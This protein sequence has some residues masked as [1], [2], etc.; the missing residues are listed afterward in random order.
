MIEIKEWHPGKA[1]GFRCK[2]PPC[3]L[4]VLCSYSG[5]LVFINDRVVLLGVYFCSALTS[6]AGP[7]CPCKAAA[8]ELTEN[9]PTITSHAVRVTPVLWQTCHALKRLPGHSHIP[10]DKQMWR[11]WPRDSYCLVMGFCTLLTL[12][13]QWV[14]PG[15]SHTWQ[16]GQPAGF[17]LL[18]PLPVPWVFLPGAGEVNILPTMANAR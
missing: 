15:G 6:P 3:L 16:A 10:A 2:C 5:A 1:S 18:H 12:K 8:E 17:P 7:Q 13:T 14:Q 11:T 4:A 9:S